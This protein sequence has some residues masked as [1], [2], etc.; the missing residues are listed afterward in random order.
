MK[1]KN[2][3]LNCDNFINWRNIAPPGLLGINKR[4]FYGFEVHSQTAAG[5]VEFLLEEIKHIKNGK[6]V[7]IGVFGGWV[8]LHLAELAL[9]NNSEVYSIDVWDKIEV[10]NG[11]IIPENELLAAR[12]YFK[13]LRHNFENILDNLKYT[14]TTVVHESSITAVDKFE[15]DSLDLIFIDGDHCRE[16]L[17]NE[18][19][20]WYPKLKKNGA[21]NGDDYNWI[22][23]PD[24]INQF[25]REN[26]LDTYTDG[27]LW[28]LKPKQ[29]K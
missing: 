17:Y 6:I 18:L 9:K 19:V 5:T 3:D 7:E 1:N 22:G 21:L 23:L 26:N 14:N 11:E 8:S 13:Q 28:S 27:R 2:V 20:L 15:N 29:T 4:Y 24:A 10:G 16:H 12:Y 25:G